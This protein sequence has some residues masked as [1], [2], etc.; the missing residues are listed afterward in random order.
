[1]VHRGNAKEGHLVTRP[2]KSLGKG[3]SSKNLKI[4]M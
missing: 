1:M 3:M 4:A 2:V